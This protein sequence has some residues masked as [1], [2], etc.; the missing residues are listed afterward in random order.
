MALDLCTITGVFYGT[1][2]LPLRGAAL[3]VRNIYVPTAVGT[4]GLVLDGTRRIISDEDGVVSFTLI[5]GAQV[6]I[7]IPGREQEITRTVTVPATAECDLVALL[8]PYLVSVAWDDPGPLSQEV[9][10]LFTI[11]A[12]GTYSDG[13]T[14]NI[15]RVCTFEK[16]VSDVVSGSG[17]SLRA[18]VPGSTEVTITGVNTGSLSRYQLPN[19]DVISR[20]D[21]PAIT[22]PD[23]LTIVVV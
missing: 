9:G 13:V 8:Y 4:D 1:N 22:L 14:E 10:D 16:S 7:E 5:Q 6:R 11:I 19:G 20:L 18:A 17:G 15:T 21:A 2:G 23:A 12:T 3:R